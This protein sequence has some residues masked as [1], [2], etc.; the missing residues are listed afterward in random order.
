MEL[1]ALRNGT[2]EHF[3]LM[4][5]PVRY[6]RD[7]HALALKRHALLYAKMARKQLKYWKKQ[8]TL[9]TILFENPLT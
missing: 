6:W 3:L 1:V 7:I 8:I 5:D 2:K 9:H 4:Q